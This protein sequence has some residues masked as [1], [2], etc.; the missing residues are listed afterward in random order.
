MGN[1]GRPK[2]PKNSQKQAFS[3]KLNPALIERIEKRAA[4]EHRSK[5]NLVEIVLDENV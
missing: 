5:N 2:G 4:K 3:T 1:K